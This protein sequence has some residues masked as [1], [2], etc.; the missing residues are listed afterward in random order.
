[1]IYLRFLWSLIRHKW[2]VL[3]AGI[4]LRIPLWRLLLHDLSKFSP[5]EFGPYAR[6]FQGDYSKSPNDRE[7]ISFEFT[8]AWLHHE[9]RN[10]HHW[11]YWIPRAGKSANIPLPMPETYVREMIA[12][13][14]G[15]SRGYTGSWDIAIWL[16]RHGPKWK[17]HDETLRYIWTVMIELEY[18]ITDNCDWS[19][20]ASQKTREILK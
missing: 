10:L 6:N 9:N 2:F 7:R 12:D 3:Q 5:S 16:N 20:M 19:W 8:F 15:A 14:L 4:I 1:M 13:C 11:G 18:F 17:I